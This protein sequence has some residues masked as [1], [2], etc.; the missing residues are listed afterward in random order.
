MSLVLNVAIQQ[1]KSVLGSTSWR[2]IKTS[3]LKCVT[4]LSS[5][6]ISL[7][8]ELNLIIVEIFGEVTAKGTQGL[9]T[10]WFNPGV[11]KPTPE[12]LHSASPA[13]CYIKLEYLH[14]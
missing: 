5:T 4:V 11:T 9:V 1:T 13:F 7:S 3:K 10:T 2:I 14:C 12:E 8:F 6:V